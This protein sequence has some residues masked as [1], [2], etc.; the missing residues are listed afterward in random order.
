MWQIMERDGRIRALGARL[1]DA[2]SRH[3]GELQKVGGLA[4]SPA[5]V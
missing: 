5:L 1:E 3:A 2:Q 4:R